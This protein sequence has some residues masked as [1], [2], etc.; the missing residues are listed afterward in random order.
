MWGHLCQ[1]TPGVL[2][3]GGSL[4]IRTQKLEVFRFQICSPGRAVMAVC[5]Q[6]NAFLS[7][8]TDLLK[9]DNTASAIFSYYRTAV[10][11]TGPRD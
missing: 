4:S 1:V 7:L 6:N 11:P 2:V 10:L 5:K 8:T 9:A 3:D